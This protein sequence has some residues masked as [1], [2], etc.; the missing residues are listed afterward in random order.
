MTDCTLYLFSHHII[1]IKIL[2]ILAEIVA[3]YQK[4]DYDNYPRVE[5]KKKIYV[6]FF[7][8]QRYDSKYLVNLEKVER[9]LRKQNLMI[10]NFSQ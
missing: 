9:N 2:I 7:Y 4:F 3:F 6:C 8:D 1:D 5:D 10:S